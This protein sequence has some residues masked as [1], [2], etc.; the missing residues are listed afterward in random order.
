MGIRRDGTHYVRSLLR[1]PEGLLGL[2]ALGTLAA[3]LVV[4][5]TT[6]YGLHRD[7]Y[8]YLA[9]GRHLDWGFIEGPPGIAL[10][11]AGL[12]ATLGTSLAAVR[13][14]PALAHGVLVLLTGLIAREL[15]GKRFA[16][17]VA[18]LAALQQCKVNLE[19]I[20]PAGSLNERRALSA[21]DSAGIWR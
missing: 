21:T 4:A 7:E 20:R 16:I 18:G 2:L 12:Q 15:G 3:H 11:A 10:V 14:V 19:S 6:A 1:S 8:L 9:Y 17:L 5:M 13:L